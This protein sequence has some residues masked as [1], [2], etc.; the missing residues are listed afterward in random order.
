MG[1]GYGLG[2][3]LCS[4]MKDGEGAQPPR[5]RWGCPPTPPPSPLPASASASSLPFKAANTRGSSS[6]PPPPG[7]AAVG[8]GGPVEAGW[9]RGLGGPVGAEWARG[10]GRAPLLSRRYPS[11]DAVEPSSCPAPSFPG[12]SFPGPGVPCTRVPWPGG[13]CSCVPRAGP[14]QPAAVA[15]VPR[16]RPSAMSA[17]TASKAR[18]SNGF[19]STRSKPRCRGGERKR[20]RV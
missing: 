10:L 7:A 1:S 4:T 11:T 16:A 20:E 6:H 12:R 13:P 2:L 9:A 8:L 5:C 3:G 18:G 19:I 14:P 15:P 17:M